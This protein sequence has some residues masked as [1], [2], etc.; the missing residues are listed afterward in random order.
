MRVFKVRRPDYGGGKWC[1]YRDVATM[2][3]GEFDG[4]EVGDVIHVELGEMTEAE[5][6][7]LPEFE[8]W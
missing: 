6:D 7:N 2:I 4:A 5:M 8:G 3:D 1:V